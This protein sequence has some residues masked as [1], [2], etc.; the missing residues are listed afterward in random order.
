[1]TSSFIKE[2]LRQDQTVFSFQE[3]LLFAK[4]DNVKALKS[5]LNYYVKRGDLYN[6]RRGLYAKDKN[7]NKLELATKIYTPSY[8]S[9]ETVLLQV[10]I[11]F[12]YYSE[13]FVATYQTKKPHH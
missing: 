9:F 4:T 8:I 13:I 7:Y 1:M 5:K 3:L 11:N 12:Q 10:G 6:I 2:L